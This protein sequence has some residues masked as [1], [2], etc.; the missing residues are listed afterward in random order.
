MRRHYEKN[1]NVKCQL[2][3]K[4]FKEYIF[5]LK[6]GAVF[7]NNIAKNGSILIKILFCIQFKM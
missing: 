3:F 5:Y 4:Y 2:L 6:F 1:P 7:L